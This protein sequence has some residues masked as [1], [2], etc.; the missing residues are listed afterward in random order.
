MPRAPFHLDSIRNLLAAHGEMRQADL[1]R[2]ADLTV[3]TL[4]AAVKPGLRTGE[5]RDRREGHSVF[6]RLAAHDSPQ[7]VGLPPAA[8]SASVNGYVPPQMIAPRAGSDVRLPSRAPG[9]AP[10][11]AVAAV[12][13][14]AAAPLPPAPK[15]A[16]AADPQPEAAVDDAPAAGAEDPEPRAF[17]AWLSG[18]SDELVL[19]GVHV[20]EYGDV[21]L[22]PEQ[23]AVVRRLL[24]ALGAAE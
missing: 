5:L 6:Y 13:P 16:P 11:S 8:P 17:E 23:V 24:L 12:A 20:D 3:G 15:P 14:V 21:T 4:I 10:A 9:A 7:V 18:V 19:Q 22:S 2:A 1:A